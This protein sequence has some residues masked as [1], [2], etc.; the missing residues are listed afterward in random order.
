MTAVSMIRL[1]SPPSFRNSA[2]FYYFPA[3][4]CKDFLGIICLSRA[5]VWIG[6]QR[7]NPWPAPGRELSGL[8]SFPGPLPP[9]LLGKSDRG[10][11]DCRAILR[12]ARNDSKR[13]RL[14]LPGAQRR[15]NL[16][17]LDTPSPEVI[18][19]VPRRTTGNRRGVFTHIAAVWAEWCD[20]APALRE[21]SR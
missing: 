12:I 17:F 10:V 13:N 16:D 15:S 19:S 18:E 14:S 7:R 3:R 4:I 2:L 9:R 1:P 8:R 11:L 20:R 5:R 6:H 21:G